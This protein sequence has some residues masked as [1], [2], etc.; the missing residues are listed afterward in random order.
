MSG[1]LRAHRHP[2]PT[3]SAGQRLAALCFQSALIGGV[4]CLAVPS[5]RLPAWT[6]GLE[7]A[8][9]ALITFGMA[10]SAAMAWPERWLRT[11]TERLVEG[12]R[13]AA[14][15]RGRHIP[16]AT[17]KVALA[18]AV[19]AARLA[20]R[21]R[22]ADNGFAPNLKAAVDDVAQNLELVALALVNEPENARRHTKTVSRG[23]VVAEAVEAHARLRAT[24]GVREDEIAQGRA[25]VIDALESLGAVME[26]VMRSTVA[27]QMLALDITTT[28]AVDLLDQD[29]ART[30]KQSA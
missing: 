4:I 8:L 26:G 2:S 16:A 29:S 6:A 7:P 25:R 23:A 14:N 3:N 22:L 18:R 12:L 1:F 27:Q 15:A 28:V 20:E 13:R 11:P 5:I 9:F 17:V 21:M 30:R 10:L 19:Q 24:R